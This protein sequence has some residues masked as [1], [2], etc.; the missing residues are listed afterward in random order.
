MFRPAGGRWERAHG[1]TQGG[2]SLL[3]LWQNEHAVTFLCGQ[4][5]AVR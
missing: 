5:A 2:C 1:V 4:S 3:G